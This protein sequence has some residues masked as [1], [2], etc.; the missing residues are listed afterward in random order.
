MKMR[1]FLGTVSISIVVGL[2]CGIVEG[3]AG[4][5]VPP[6]PETVMSNE[7]DGA[8]AWIVKGCNAC[9][10]DGEGKKMICGVGSV[11][12]T[13]NPAIA[14]EAAIARARTDIARK[15]Q[16]NIGAMLK[17]Y[18]A[19]TTGG[20]NFGTEASDEQHIVDISKQV[21]DMS[22][23]G[24]ELIDSWV[25]R[26]GTFYALVAMDENK[27]KDSINKMGNLSESLR[28]A[29]IQRSDRAFTDLDTTIEQKNQ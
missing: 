25:S 13:R 23:K 2:I 12:G 5:S 11:G 6:K 16:V 21:T 3:C 17:D 19:T 24:T 27:F 26:N 20:E 7:F 8:P 29:I 28:K 18:Q 4:K 15:L 22:L 9:W 1:V 10:K 14:R